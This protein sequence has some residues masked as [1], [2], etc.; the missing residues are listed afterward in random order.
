[1]KDPL[2]FK[3]P[4][5]KMRNVPINPP[6]STLLSKRSDL[7]VPLIEARI[8]LPTFHHIVGLG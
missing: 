2:I 3:V 1:V 4:L 8:F 6:L 7:T 5:L